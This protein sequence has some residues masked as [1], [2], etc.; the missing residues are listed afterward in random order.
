MFIYIYKLIK[1]GAINDDM[2][3]IGSTADVSNRRNNHKINTYN[4]CDKLRYNS[5]V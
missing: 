2:V 5:K 1:K 4:E 3:Y